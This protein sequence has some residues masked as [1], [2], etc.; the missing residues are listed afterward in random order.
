MV[1]EA[2][3][4]PS[5]TRLELSVKCN[6]SFPCRFT[7]IS[8]DHISNPSHPPPSLSARQWALS[9]L[10]ILTLERGMGP[11]KRCR[12]RVTQNPIPSPIASSHFDGAYDTRL[13]ELTANM[14]PMREFT[15]HTGR[16]PV[17]V[18]ELLLL[19]RTCQALPLATFL[20]AWPPH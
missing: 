10:C 17:H 3:K 19:A 8:S 4:N 12:K 2:G 5:C 20:E 15:T 6:S 14:P 18:V 7:G 9:I 1:S 16:A 11:A 13:A